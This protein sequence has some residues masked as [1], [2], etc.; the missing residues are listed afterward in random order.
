MRGFNLNNPG[1][2][3]ISDSP[4]VGKV[5]STDASFE[6][7]GDL[8]DGLRAMML[9][10]KNSQDKHGV[11]NL[12]QLINRYAPPSENDTGGYVQFVSAQTGIDPEAPLDLSD[13][14]NLVPITKAM[15]RMEQGQDDLIDDETYSIAADRAFGNAEDFSGFAD[16]VDDEQP[17][18]FSGMGMLDEPAQPPKNA[19]PIAF[20]EFDPENETMTGYVADGLVDYYRG[21]IDQAAQ[22]IPFYDEAMYGVDRM[23]S[24]PEAAAGRRANYLER[25]DRF[26]DEN[27]KASIAS[28]IGGTILTGNAL[29]KGVQAAAPLT[30]V[31]ASAV[32]AV[33]SFAKSRPLLTAG[34]TGG[35][36]NAVYSA[37]QAE[38]GV[39][40][41]VDDAASGFL[42]G[43]PAGVAGAKLVQSGSNLVKTGA[44]YARENFPKMFSM[45]D[46]IPDAVP[47][48]AGANVADDI[49]GAVDNVDP[50]SPNF[51]P[52]N[53]LDDEALARL[54]DGKVL[55]MTRGDRTQNAELQAIEDQ[56]LRLGDD[57][58]VQA[59]SA[60]QDD[61]YQAFQK[62][63]GGGILGT[64][65]DLVNQGVND[66][67]NATR[68]ADILRAQ[69]DDLG[70]QVNAAYT[71]AREGA[72]GVG[73]RTSSIYD[74]LRRPI[75]DFF[76]QEVYRTG[77]IPKLD[78]HMEELK[79]ILGE[80]T[81]E[82][83]KTASQ[84]KSLEAWKKRLNR[85]ISNTTEPGDLRILQNVSRRYDNFLTNLSDDAIVNGDEAAVK[86]F[87]EARGLASKKFAFYESDKAIQRI[88]DNREL[89]GQQLANT[90]YGAGRLAGKGEDGR[91]VERMIEL[92]GP[93]AG[94]MQEAIK[95]GMMARMLE[96][97]M[98]K[99][100]DPVK[101]AQGIDRSMISFPKLV[102]EL[103]S[104]INKQPEAFKAT[105]SDTEQ[106]FLKQMLK[107]SRQLSSK[108]AGTQNV[109]N[110]WIGLARF[111]NK[112]PGI[113]GSPI[114]SSLQKLATIHAEQE[115]RGKATKNLEEFIGQ[116]IQNI[117]VPAR[118]YGALGG[119]VTPSAVDQAIDE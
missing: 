113:G 84:L 80:S 100:L 63:L 110:S 28:N 108:Q 56:A 25:L 4:W 62:S 45:I 22:G 97:S 47:A 46:D 65:D 44:E 35:G 38:G 82:N 39:S 93:R 107:E 96:R 71:R 74:D 33:N 11:Q 54:Q 24:G 59:R 115:V 92:S 72:E 70:N 14:A 21:L 104:L 20:R 23:I 88:L 75:D 30:P 26:S 52:A 77:D 12:A 5:A 3:R 27:P 17:A 49:A 106:E 86:A 99:T 68:A 105:F 48:V 32:N 67:A 102:D 53:M 118:Y 111:L 87:K 109:S 91:I 40:D 41:R 15:V 69:Y 55:R 89:T 78:A 18:D 66:A 117:D 60:Q 37:G 7:F 103:S 98:T 81:G 2:L 61:A 13:K 42:W 101:S 16:S 31:T 116:Q 83:F 6:Q 58:M 19:D 51:T 73:I 10:I 76:E 9:N 94:E 36:G 114:G 43:F 119:G 90:I 57:R 29:L 112:V 79:T 64:P 1:N 85:T 50:I 95:R 34:L 8:E